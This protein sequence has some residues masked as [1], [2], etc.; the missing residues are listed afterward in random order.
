MKECMKN[1]MNALIFFNF[2]AP[3]KEGIQLPQGYRATARRQFTFY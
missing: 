2:I 3:F 1:M